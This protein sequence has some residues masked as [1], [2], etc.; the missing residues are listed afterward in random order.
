[1]VERACN[2]AVRILHI[3]YD[4]TDSTNIG[5]AGEFYV[6]AQLAQRGFVASFTL[7]N[8]KGID[9]LV[10]N[11]PFNHFVKLEVKTTNKPPRKEQPFYPD[12]VYGWPMSEKHEKISDPQTFYCFVVLQEP[13]TLPLFFVVPS[14]YVAEYVCEQHRYWVRTRRESPDPSNKMRRFRIHPSDPLGFKDN[15]QLL[16]GVSPTPQQSHVMEPWVSHEH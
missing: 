11:A 8:R 6:L 16:G 4:R 9:I 12:L 15:W 1:M 5:I 13:S 14:S 7:A 10:T 3:R 2:A